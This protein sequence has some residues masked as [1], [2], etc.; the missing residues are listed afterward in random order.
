MKEERRIESVETQYRNLMER[1]KAPE[2]LK[3]KT[4]LELTQKKRK[5]PIGKLSLALA[6][7][8]VI[9]N[10]LLVS[11]K[12]IEKQLNSL[13]IILPEETIPLETIGSFDNLKVIAQ[14]NF[15]MEEMQKQNNRLENL[16]DSKNYNDFSQTNIQ[17]V[18]VDEEDTIKTDG[19]YVYQVVDGKIVI[20]DVQNPNKIEVV[21]E[22]KAE[23]EENRIDGIYLLEKKIIAISSM[24]T[25]TC[26]TITEGEE[27]I[28]PKRQVKAIIYNMEDIVHPKEERRVVVDGYYTN[29]RM[30]DGNLYLVV[31]Q[32]LAIGNLAKENAI[33]DDFKPTYRDT[34]QSEEAIKI[35]YNK[36][37]RLP[38]EEQMSYTI[39]AA[40]PVESGEKVNVVSFLGGSSNLYCSQDNLYIVNQMLTGN[41]LKTIDSMYEANSKIYKFSLKDAKVY[42]VGEVVIPGMVLNSF[43]MGEK[44]G[45]FRIATTSKYT[46]SEIELGKQ[47][48]GNHE[49]LKERDHYNNVY[50]LDE[51]MQVMG[52]VEELALEERIYSARFVGDKCYLV[53]FKQTDPFFVIDLEDAKNPKVLGELKI[54]GYSGYLHSWDENHVIGIGY[55]VKQTKNGIT[56]G[57]VKITLFNVEEE[58]DP[59]ELSTIVMGSSGTYS[60][61]TYEHKAVFVNK[62]KGWIGFPITIREGRTNSQW[63]IIYEIKMVDGKMELAE[64]G[65]ITHQDKSRKYEDN[66]ERILS[67]GDNIITVS[68]NGIQIHSAN[69]MEQIGEYRRV[70]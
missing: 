49:I 70:E 22:I 9:T 37:Y 43:S 15:S 56:N 54:D 65:R 60:E 64:K 38:E 61:A 42:Y 48:E 55:E 53:T 11:N 8:L 6:M 59:K 23:A 50:V 68:N 26:A 3:R 28:A 12:K 62:T 13:E 20:Y 2:E 1:M 40:V 69:T 67:I 32:N 31:N 29:S 57:G 51:K 24:H 21:S 7:V 44:D 5:F 47:T 18:G 66:I 35:D 25:Y 36:I 10:M 46:L 45:K 52:K 30:I 41:S 33:A 63:A 34:V 16:E 14:K 4:I 27:Y 17:E 19:K 58:E 39:I